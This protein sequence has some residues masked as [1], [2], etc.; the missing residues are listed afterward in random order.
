[1]FSFDMSGSGWTAPAR[2][3]LLSI[4][5][6]F[7][8]LTGFMAAGA[9]HLS[10]AVHVV[11]D[12]ENSA[13]SG[14]VKPMKF[15][16]VEL[17]DEIDRSAFKLVEK[18]LV[19]AVSENADYVIL[20][21]NTYGGAVDAADRIRSALIECEIPVAVF[22]NNQAVSAGALISIACDSIYMKSGAT[23]G[24]ASV[25]NQSGDVMPDKYQSFMRSM[26]R[27]TAE[28][29]GRDPEIAESMVMT[30]SAKVLS[31]TVSEAVAAGYCEG[32]VS[33][34]EDV[35]RMIAPEA[36]ASGMYEIADQT[37]SVAERILLVLLSPVLQALFMM[38]IIGGIYFELQ[39]P[40]IGFPLAVAVTG[41][42]LY[43]APL[44]IEGLADNWELALFIA[45]LILLAVE[46]FVI[47]GFGVA[48]VAGIVSVIVSLSFAMIDNDIFRDGNF[49]TVDLSVVVRPFGFV[50]IVFFVSVALAI[51][52]ASRLFPSGM[53]RNITLNSSLR[54][55]EGFVAAS[56]EECIAPGTTVIAVTPLRPSGKVEYEG[57]WY[58]AVLDYGYADKGTALKVT[59]YGNGRVYCSIQR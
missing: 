43:F 59:G 38:M 22:I 44:Y 24:A 53:F 28:V 40:G 54:K 9:D 20:D 48:G 21:L 18:G 42:V 37:F 15:L 1:M 11:G 16:R 19:Q 51:Y 50:T 3:Y 36:Y 10:V 6:I 34:V 58:D 5:S 46:I 45:G 57:R 47:P 8:T 12:G 14:V 4:L 27:S 2:K 56:V 30:D 55:E 26:M 13:G 17:H 39:S 25:V 31:L 29:N 23:I 32:E 33:S 41:A 49:E 52:V 35:V 7:F